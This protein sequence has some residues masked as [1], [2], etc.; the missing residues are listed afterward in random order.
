MVLTLDLHPPSK[1]QD[2]AQ[3]VYSGV[4]KSKLQARGLS[5]VYLLSWD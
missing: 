3:T 4:S 5:A 1:G 2:V